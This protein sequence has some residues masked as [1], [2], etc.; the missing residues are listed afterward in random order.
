MIGNLKNILLGDISVTVTSSERVCEDFIIFVPGGGVKVGGDRFADW[1][2][3]LLC[4]GVGSCTLDFPGV[5]KSLGDVRESSLSSRE[6][7]VREVVSWVGKNFSYRKLSIYGVSMGGSIILGGIDTENEIDGSYILHCPAA[8]SQLA[9][10]MRFSEGFT[11]EIRKEQS[12]QDSKSFE[13]LL[14]LKN[15]V[16]FILHEEEEVIPR[17]VIDRYLDILRLK[18]NKQ[19]LRV[20]GAKH[21]VNKLSEEGKVQDAGIITAIERFL[22]PV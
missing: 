8:Y 9:E 16:L 21:I 11:E 1:Q 3:I 14:K 4:K 22:Q 7:I 2:E 10:G 20:K 15:Q 6:E 13:R 18:K 5:G 19:I 12:W 17:G